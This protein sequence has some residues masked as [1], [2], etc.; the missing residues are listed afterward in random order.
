MWRGCSDVVDFVQ[1]LVME[2]CMGGVGYVRVWMDEWVE[3]GSWVVLCGGWEVGG[4]GWVS[5]GGGGGRWGGGG[6][7]GGEGRETR[8]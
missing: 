3:G 5:G 6:G 1:A 8:G 2:L 7:K 4:G